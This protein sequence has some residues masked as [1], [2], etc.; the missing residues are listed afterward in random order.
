MKATKTETRNQLREL[1]IS[2]LKSM[3]IAENLLEHPEIQKN[4]ECDKL[5]YNLIYEIEC[6]LFNQLFPIQENLKI[7]AKE[8]KEEEIKIS[9]PTTPTA[10]PENSLFD[11]FAEIT[12]MN[13]RYNTQIFNSKN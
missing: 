8:I 6:T 11:I 12:R 7:K 3:Q 2:I 1:H 9:A 5:M 13:N 4:L 10:A